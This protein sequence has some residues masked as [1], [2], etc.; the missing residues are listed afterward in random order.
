MVAQG[1]DEEA[2]VWTEID[3]LSRHG[4]AGHLAYATFR[5]R[6]LP[7]GSG[8]IESAIRRVINL[9]M[10][11]NSIFWKEENA[12]GMLV[13]RGLVLSR[14]WKETF[15]KISASLAGDRRLDWEWHAPDMAAELKAAAAIAPPTP[16]PQP[17][18][19]PCDVA[20]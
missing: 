2:P 7:V 3:Y 14:R 16:Q 13:L 5:R 6:K 15:A 20:A 11:G 8:A 1:L 19:T 9:R 12:E 10:K 4:E 17:S 18:E